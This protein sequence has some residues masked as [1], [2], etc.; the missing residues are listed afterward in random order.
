MARDSTSWLSRLF[1]RDGG[2][3]RGPV[4]APASPTARRKQES[5][6]HAVSLAVGRDCCRQVEALIGTRFL[7]AEAPKLPLAGC[8][9]RTCG[10]RYVHHVDRRVEAD[11]RLRD[12]WKLGV[13]N[14]GEE[15]RKGRGRRDPDPA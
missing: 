8:D 15:R 11:R 12:L 6:Y 3:S 14:S 7:A 2:A 9:V 5:P 10:C 4:V 13:V 1:G